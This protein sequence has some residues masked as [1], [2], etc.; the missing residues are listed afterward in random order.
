[1]I[2]KTMIIRPLLT[3]NNKITSN[4]NYIYLIG[5]KKKLPKI[6]VIASKDKTK[7]FLT[8]LAC[9][10]AKIWQKKIQLAMR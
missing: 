4:I 10:F 8:F 1:M 7:A 2:K 9:Y 6:L 3:W 5:E